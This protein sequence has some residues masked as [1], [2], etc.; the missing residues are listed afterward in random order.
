[1]RCGHFPLNTYLHKINK[2]ESNWCLACD[3]DQEGLSPPETLNHY[4]FKCEA[5]TEAR[6]ELIEEIVLDQFHFPNIMSD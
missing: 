4:I 5:Y 6:N 3:V 2:A 1:M